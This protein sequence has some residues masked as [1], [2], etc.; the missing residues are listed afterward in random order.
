MF[1]S[2]FTPSFYKIFTLIF[3]LS[4]AVIY[5]AKD[6]WIEHALERQLQSIVT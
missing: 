1:A 3:F 6:I 4:F 2:D 5:S